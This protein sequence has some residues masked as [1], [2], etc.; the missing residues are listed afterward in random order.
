MGVAAKRLGMM[1]RR[2][3][4]TGH[5]QVRGA[6]RIDLMYLIISW[7]VRRV[8][9]HAVREVGIGDLSDRNGPARMEM[10]AV[11]DLLDMRL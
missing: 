2:R 4:R 11:R 8:K 6:R 9:V 3:N 10:G 5:Q 1:L 7:C